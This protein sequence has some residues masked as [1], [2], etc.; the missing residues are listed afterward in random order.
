[1]DLVLASQTRILLSLTCGTLESAISALRIGAI[2][3]IG[4]FPAYALF[5]M[6]MTMFTVAF[7]PFRLLSA[8]IHVTL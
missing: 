8:I 3:F 5:S 7:I 6:V 4:G 1:L 2:G